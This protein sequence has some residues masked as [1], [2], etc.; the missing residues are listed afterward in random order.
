MYKLF[1]GASFSHETH[2]R[3]AFAQSLRQYRPLERLIDTE[4]KFPETGVR[5]DMRT[6]DPT[7]IIREWEFKLVAD[8]TAL[9]Q[10]LI[11]VSLARKFYGPKKIVRGVLAAFDFPETIT[12]S[13]E[14]LNLGIEVYRLPISL[15]SAGMIP[16]DN[17]ASPAPNSLFKI[18]N[19]HSL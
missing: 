12:Y 3:D 15:R 6:I 2:I 11:Y 5:V 14:A 10:I 17:Y 8:Y 7:E 16:N 19:L 9:G 1:P 4:V 13:I 18:P